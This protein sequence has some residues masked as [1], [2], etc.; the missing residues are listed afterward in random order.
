MQSVKKNE[1]F[2][3]V[4]IIPFKQHGTIANMTHAERSEYFYHVRTE[5]ISKANIVIFLSGEKLGKDGA[6]ANSDTVMT[7][8]SQA[9]DAGRY[10]IPVATFGGSSAAIFADMKHRS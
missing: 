4:C 1:V 6:T 5:L 2:Q 9:V 7:E 8:Y 10:C 3:Y